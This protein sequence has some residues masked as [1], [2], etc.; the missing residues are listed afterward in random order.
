MQ[1]TSSVLALLQDFTPVFIAP[2]VT[3]FVQIVTGRLFSQQRLFI[4]EI[5]FSGG[6]VGD[7]S[8]RPKLNTKSQNASLAARRR[9]TFST[10]L[11]SCRR[12]GDTAASGST[13][14]S[15]ADHA[16][17]SRPDRR[18]SN[19][20]SPSPGDDHALPLGNQMVRETGRLLSCKP[21]HNPYACD[22]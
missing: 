7:G 16:T 11:P 21:S 15:N 18:D 14:Q 2:T 3:A 12:V 8:P 5:I 6:N 20:R 10:L 17:A 1:P 19:T 4:T 13:R 22:A 9:N